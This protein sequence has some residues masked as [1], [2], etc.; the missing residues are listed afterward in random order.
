M[1]LLTTLLILT[2]SCG[3]ATANRHLDG[4]ELYHCGFEQSSDRDYDGW[5]DGWTRQRGPGYPHYVQVQQSQEPSAEGRQCLRI[6]LDGGAAAAF[7]PPIA[8]DPRHDYALEAFLKVDGLKH[9]EAFLSVRFLDEKRAVLETFESVRRRG[10]EAWSAVRLGPLRCSHDAAKFAVIGVHV[11]PTGLADLNGIALFD[12][13]WFAQIPRM[14]LKA[15][16]EGMLHAA[17]EPIL[18]DFQVSGCRTNEPV[19]RIEVDDALG[20]RLLEAKL[21][22]KLE[23]DS[24]QPENSTQRENQ[25]AEEQPYL[26]ASASWRLPFDSPGYYRVRAT[27]AGASGLMHVR[28]LSLAVAAAAPRRERGEF[29]WTL[30]E[31]EAGLPLAAVVQLAAQSGVQWVK[32][33][34]WYDERDQQRVEQL[35]WMADRLNSQG[36]GLIGLLFDPPSETK[37]ALGLSDAT[38]AADLFSQPP[39]SWYP[40]LEPIMARMS[41]KVNRWQLGRD[42][43]TSFSGLKDP[44]ATFVRVKQQLDRIG[45]DAHLGVGWSWLDETPSNKRPPWSFLSRAAD[46]AMTAGELAAYLAPN[47]SNAGSRAP[48]WV[49]LEPLSADRYSVESRAA[50]LIERMAAAKEH[51]AAKIF[52]SAPVG[53]EGLVRSEGSPTELLL[54]WRTAALAL[55]GAEYAGRLELPQGSENRVFIRGQETVV[56]V[57]NSAPA[58]ETVY[59][60]HDIRQIDAWGR[61][62]ETVADETGRRIEVGP[63]PT[64]ILGADKELV[65]WQMSV[66]LDKAQLPSIFGTPHSV[67]LSLR[68]GFDHAANGQVRVLTTGGWRAEPDKFE[69]KLPAETEL[70]E[71]LQLTFPSTASCGPQALRF[72]FDITTDRRYQFSVDREIELGTGDVFL[73][74]FSHVNSADEL[75]VEQRLVN[76]TADEISFR[77]HLSIPNRR[78][79]RTQVLKMG[80]GEDVQIYRVPDGASLVGEQL[81]IRAEEIGGRRR[82]LNYV[83]AAEP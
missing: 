6:D 54:P 60:G 33:P 43:D 28:E 17:G 19:V 55:A 66:M 44:L 64:F 35:T 27:L 53:P 77:C 15:A 79:M 42:E 7:S 57:W 83:F 23:G 82:I 20:R 34:L 13:V 14:T 61:E 29:G 5:P 73:R 24:A 18:L 16:A 3:I 45:Q 58:E 70:R 8:I 36:I 76:R 59:L 2:A 26:A 39:E 81:S 12:D 37:R 52:F 31:G 4:R 10:N 56:V 46:P 63:L 68:N 40:A 21:P 74:I 25:A 71:K 49:S 80:P 11:Q 41:L 38:S 50:D 30:S 48:Q 32:F 78:R 62:I 51:G 69:I 47:V 67:I 1:N 22:L 75:E 65:R 9:D 72:A